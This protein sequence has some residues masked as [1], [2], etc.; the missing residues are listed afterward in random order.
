MS[1]ATRKLPATGP[2]SRLAGEVT[3]LAEP[4][5]PRR[6]WVVATNERVLKAYDLSHF[7]A[8]DR[9]RV[10]AEAEIAVALSD[11][12]GV[13]TTYGFEQADGWLAIEMERLG[14]TLA[15]YL[16]AVEERTRV[17]LSPGSCGA[18]IESVADTLGEVH[19]RRLMHRDIK[20]ANLIFDRSGHRLL[21]ADFSL[22]KRRPRRGGGAAGVA[23]TRSYIAPEVFRGQIGPAADQYG[24][25]VTAGEML[26]GS[27]TAAAQ[28]VL[29]RATEQDPGDRYPSIA[30]FGLALRA[31]LDDTAPR[32]ISSRLQR[33]SVKWRQTWAAGAAAF[34]ATYVWLL[35]SRRPTLSWED[36][37]VL[38]LLAMGL[39]MLATRMLNPLRGGRSR[40]RLAI[41]DRGWFP[42][43]PFA[44]A[45]AA[46][47][48]LLNDDP[49]QA[50]RI[51]G[52]A[53]LGSLALAAVLGSQRPNAGDWLIRL[54]RRWEGRRAPQRGRPALWW[55]GR[56]AIGIVLALLA[57]L[58]FAAAERWPGAVPAT[59]AEGAPVVL[60]AKLRTALLRKRWDVACALTRIPPVP[61]KAPCREWAPV[62]GRWL[63]SDRR[64][65]AAP[66]DERQLAELRLPGIP[67]AAR[68]GAPLWRIRDRDNLDVGTVEQQ[69]ER[70]R[71][72]E[73]TIE[74]GPPVESS[75]EAYNSI[76]NYDVV[77]SGGRWWITA[78]ESCDFDADPACV[79][80]SQ[81]DRSELENVARRG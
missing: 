34:V 47:S 22:A 37:L 21:V 59:P 62:A 43:L 80:L 75:L 68:I 17:P 54:V 18:L 79:A 32:R 35:G 45:I 4:S 50:G 26:G 78:V 52:F 66:L 73:V 40:P 31:A 5:A 56:L 61:K 63:Q 57:A 64:D 39:T 2:L 13:V 42:V 16:Q 30:D 58:P 53:G 11:L 12:D 49:S 46:T 81:T 38:P 28:P 19:R 14:E 1:E 41:A 20:P 77:K 74:R 23:G 55:G 71:V 6:P 48:P 10:I 67:D 29:L 36:G 15:D 44:I 76:W 9:A 33:V 69:D 72:W 70:G 8:I 24:L 27:V 60:V 65:G 51:V 25:G 7:D 3:I